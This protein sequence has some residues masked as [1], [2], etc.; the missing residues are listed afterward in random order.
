MAK[1]KMINLCEYIFIKVLLTTLKVVPK[2][3]GRFLLKITYLFFGMT[4][5]VRK[6]VV[7]QQMKSVYQ[8]KSHKEILSLM[9]KM[10]LHLAEVSYD[11][12]L[13]DKNYS[14]YISVEGW[15]NIEKGLTLSKGLIMISGHIGNWEI[16]GRYLAEQGIKV[17]VVIKRLHNR[18]VNDFIV[19]QREQYNINIIYKN[20]NIR[21][22][23]KALKNNEVVVMLVDQNAGKSGTLTDFLGQPASVFDGFARLAVK[24]EVPV[25]FGVAIKDSG[26]YRF[27]FDEPLLPD[28]NADKQ[29]AIKQLLDYSNKRLEYYINHYP[30][31]WFWL[32][33]KWKG[34]AKLQEKDKSK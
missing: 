29:K 6:K 31:Q 4:I 8:S 7:Y 9:K 13:P 15:G 24:N 28:E 3:L 14:K 10:Y 2:V 22:V 30:E 11:I 12:F 1:K 16:A 23:L 25:V 26:K 20:E 18:F 27:I 21:T 33:R 34:A 17:N 5:G 19:R 32:H